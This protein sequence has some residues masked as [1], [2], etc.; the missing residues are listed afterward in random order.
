MPYDKARALILAHGWKPFPRGCGG[1]PVDGS[2]CRRFPELGYCQGTS[3][4]YCGMTFAKVG[5]C[6]SLMT[7]EAPPDA[8][9]DTWI[10][11]ATV[12][13]GNCPKED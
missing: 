11:D 4:G 10:V 2:T 12:A 5:R 1:P 6:L 9:D 13:H 3:P 7:L 8:K